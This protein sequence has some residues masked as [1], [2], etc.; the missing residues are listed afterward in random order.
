MNEAQVRAAKAM[1][2]SGEM[3]AAEVAAQLGVSPST[4]YRHLPGGR[5]SLEQAA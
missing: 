1:L 2:R 4:L 5:G 3:T